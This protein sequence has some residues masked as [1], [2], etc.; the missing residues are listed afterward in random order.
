[1]LKTLKKALFLIGLICCIQFFIIGILGAARGYSIQSYVPSYISQ[2]G[3]LILLC[4][5]PID[6]KKSFAISTML[7]YICIIG[8]PQ[9]RYDKNG[10][11]LYKQKNYLGALKEFEKECET[12]YLRLKYNYHEETSLFGIAKCYSQ[13]EE[14]DKAKLTYEKMIRQFDD[15]YKKR[16]EESLQTLKKGL[17][18]IDE[19][20]KRFA[21]LEDDKEKSGLLF[22]LALIYRDM[23]CDI[24]AIECYERVQDL[25]GWDSRKEQAK[26]FAADLLKRKN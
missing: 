20:E 26:E 5:G 4:I 2:L 11:L 12:W 15:Y 25:D 24:K 10:Q 16:A 3:I 8:M 1:M 14:F 21:S 19:Y 13:L 7:I 9:G 18:D 6:V 23:Y 22:D 17:V